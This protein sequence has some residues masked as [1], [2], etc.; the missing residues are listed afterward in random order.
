MWAMVGIGLAISLSVLGAAW[1]VDFNLL[2]FYIFVLIHENKV[3]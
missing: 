3:I 2:I 1:F